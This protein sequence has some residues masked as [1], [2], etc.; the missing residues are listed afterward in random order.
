M[1]LQEFSRSI[2]EKVHMHTVDMLYK[3]NIQCSNQI[4]RLDNFSG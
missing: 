4:S 2:Q 1:S 3:I